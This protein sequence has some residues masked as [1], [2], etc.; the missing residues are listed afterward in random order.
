MTIFEITALI[1][2]S[3]IEINFILFARTD[4][5]GSACVIW[6][7]LKDPSALFLFCEA[8]C[9]CFCVS[10]SFVWHC[11]YTFVLISLLVTDVVVCD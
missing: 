5:S 8:H 4:T 1:K 7:E 2:Y 11:L 3:N 9:R 10:D 6:V